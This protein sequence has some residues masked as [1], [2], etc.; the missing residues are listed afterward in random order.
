MSRGYATVAIEFQ[1]SL[2]AGDRFTPTEPHAPHYGQTL[3]VE[4]LV[5]WY[6]NPDDCLYWVVNE[7]GVEHH[8]RCG[9]LRKC[10]RRVSDETR[11]GEAM[12]R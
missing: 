8:I 3:T 12:G 5:K 6:K 9:W 4:G 2:R 7:E 1:A 10:C 11:D